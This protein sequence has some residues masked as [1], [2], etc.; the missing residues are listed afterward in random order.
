MNKVQYRFVYNR[1]SEKLRKGM[2]ALIQ[3]EARIGLEKK[4]FST[5]VR[6]EKFQWKDN[7]VI[8]HPNAF[9]YNRELARQRKRLED[10]EFSK[11][12]K[13]IKFTLAMFEDWKLDQ[14]G[15]RNFI[16]FIQGEIDK[17][18]NVDEIREA[19]YQNHLKLVSALKDFGKI[20]DFSDVTLKRIL[21]FDRYIRSR[22]EVHAQ[23]TVWSYH[24]RMKTYVQLA[25][26]NRHLRIEDNPYLSFQVD[27]GKQGERKFLTEEE[28]KKIEEKVLTIDRLDRVRDVFVFCCYT[29]FAFNDADQLTNEN[30]VEQDGQW[31]IKSFRGKTNEE[32][33]VMVL[34]KAF[35][36]IQKYRDFRIGR[37]LPVITNQRMNAYLKEIGDLAGVD[38]KLTTHVARHTFATT[39][40]L[41]NGIP[42]E[43]LQK[44]LGHAKISTT[45]IYAKIMDSRIADEMIKLQGKLSQ[46]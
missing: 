18:Y 29:G 35:E 19:T 20:K 40:A 33:S 16:D 7:Q 27:R 28:L 15:K 34:P 44:M 25:I 22:D 24:K 4:Y 31:F 10:F 6:I 46:E 2:K 26:K 30:L 3:I 1:K 11:A 9:S 32:V 17:R 45:Q 41:N 23:T 38:K 8:K 21:D 42:L 13:G 39:I 43:V 37:L 36:I 5:G 12:D 14:K